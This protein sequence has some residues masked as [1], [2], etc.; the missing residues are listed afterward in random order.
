LRENC[1]GLSCAS[2][3]SMFEHSVSM[4]PHTPPLLSPHRSFVD[5]PFAEI[6]QSHV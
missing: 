4:I 5:L 6:D 1:S 3:L 2:L